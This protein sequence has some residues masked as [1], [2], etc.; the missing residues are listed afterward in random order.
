MINIPEE[1]LAIIKQLE[2]AGYEAVA[3]GGCV[4]D[5]LI[6]RP[7]ND[8]DV[9]TDARPE[10]LQK[11]F[12]DSFYANRFGT[13]TVK[14]GSADPT[15]QEV[16][17]TTYRIEEKYTDKRHPDKVIFAT[18]LKTDL[19]RR[20]FTINAIALQIKDYKLPTTNY[21]LIDPFDGQNDLKKK[22]IRAVGDPEARFSEDALRLLRAVRLAVTL[23][24]EIEPATA[25][26][27]KHQAPLLANMARERLRDE[28][29]KIIQYTPEGWAEAAAKR[30]KHANELTD[31]EY[32]QSGARGFE[33]L[34]ELGLLEQVL[35]ELLEGWGVYQNKHHA[36]TVWEHNLK[37]F[38]YSVKENFPWLTRLAALFHD[39]GKPKTK[40]GEGPDCTFY[41][42]DLLGAKITKQ[43]MRR[44]RFS[45]KDT[46]YVSKLVRYHMFQSDP[47]KIT[48][49]AVRRIVRNI[50]AA[51][52]WDLINLRLCDRIGSGVPK[53]EPFRLRKFLVMLEKALRQPVSLK[54][55][56]INGDIMIAELGF[57][58]GLRMGFILR[59]LMK[60][61]LDDPAK[62]NLDW[63]KKRTLALNKH[64]DSELSDLA[65]LANQKMTEIEYKKEE[66]TKQKYWVT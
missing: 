22:L 12:P 18:D 30:T 52:I 23:N 25:A 57:K 4:R 13:V 34:R 63:L 17:I 36:F 16:Q 40:M 24:F 55:M 62:N 21:K 26:A 14:T 20:D 7:P 15:L 64:S 6:G 61:I 27:I 46:E 37:S 10:E 54:Q 58:P 31:Q 19:G 60:E 65:K 5:L 41:G 39:I 47:E 43:I 48:D 9:T 2:V 42:H 11:I 29:I 1:V 45:A 49:S 8:W 35:P 28:L 59:A 3:V 66:E 38:A 32:E 53:A 56:K 50:G 44:L 33:L 51:Q